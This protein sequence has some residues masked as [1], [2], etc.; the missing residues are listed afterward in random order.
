MNVAYLVVGACA[1]AALLSWAAVWLGRAAG[2]RLG[3]VEPGLVRRP[4]R[5]GGVAVLLAVA[6]VG[7]VARLS[8]PGPWAALLPWILAI[9]ALG[10]L[11]DVFDLPPRI[12]LF[13]EVLVCLGAASHVTFDPIATPSGDGLRLG[14]LA[15]PFTVA[16]LL[17][18]VNA[19]NIVDGADGLAGGLGAVLAGAI[20]LLAMDRGHPDLAV[21][22]ALY[23]GAHL[24]FLVLN[25]APARL[26]LGDAGSLGAGMA[27][28]L[29]GI[30][31]TNPPTAT[32]GLHT[33]VLLFWLPLCEMALTVGRRLIRGQPIFHGDDRHIHHMLTASGRR[34]DVSVALL[35]LLA[36]TAATAAVVSAGWRTLPVATLIGAL[37]VT[38]VLGVQLLG[39]VELSVLG[40]RFVRLVG[41]ARHRG[42]T[43][44]KI[45]EVARHLRAATAWPDLRRH[46]AS[47]VEAEVLDEI[48]IQRSDATAE[49]TGT[50][51]WVLKTR[52][53]ADGYVL[54]VRASADGR[55]SVR[56]EDV[57]QYLV[58][59]LE[60]TIGRFD[61][62]RLADDEEA[63][64]L[65]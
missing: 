45:A 7:S 47:L 53:G 18:I 52:V 33:N 55:S 6:I 1:L 32:V 5:L 15:V 37:C 10:V 4:P 51:S 43:L 14:I 23:A 27:L 30:A 17:L 63:K 56:P 12:K 65:A 49:A 24:G 36:A 20:A 62:A 31:G 58:P 50:N 46:L 3:G 42:R 22:M 35:L 26:Y 2:G 44:V 8:L 54:V 38:T 19:F 34:M 21:W 41:M 16:W 59:A 48:S 39:Y 29:A 61:R 9:Y 57:R 64:G 40:N 28:A 13:V 11:D 60:H 25:W